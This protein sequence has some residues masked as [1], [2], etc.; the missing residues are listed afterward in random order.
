MAKYPDLR[1]PENSTSLLAHLDAT[2]QPTSVERRKF[3]EAARGFNTTIRHFPKNIIA[4]MFGFEKH[5][6]FEAEEGSEKAP[7]VKF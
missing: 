4:G 7:E 1:A 3:N 6:Y 2:Q 5:P